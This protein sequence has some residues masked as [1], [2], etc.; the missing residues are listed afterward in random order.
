MCVRVLSTLW[1]SSSVNLVKLPQMF[2][3]IGGSKQT[4]A[5]HPVLKAI[6]QKRKIFSFRMTQLVKGGS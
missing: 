6:D 2:E 5:G 4:D 3:P 1:I